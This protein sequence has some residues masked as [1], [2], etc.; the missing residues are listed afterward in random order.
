VGRHPGS[1]GGT[2]DAPE[3][4]P[5]LLG[6]DA[7]VSSQPLRDAHLSGFAADGEWD[8]RPPSAEL[9]VALEAASGPEWR[10]LGATRDEMTGLLRQWQA[11]ESWAAAGKLGVLRALVRDDGQ[12]LPGGGYRGDLP[13]GWTRSLTHEVALALSMPAASAERLMWLAWNLQALLPGTGDLLAAG[14]LTLPKAR[15]VDT[16]LNLLSLEDAARAEALIVP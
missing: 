15:A 10:C 3:P 13:E 12:P 16:A 7:P 11:L 1:H 14:E 9:A 2:G 4:G 5:G 8:A 6:P